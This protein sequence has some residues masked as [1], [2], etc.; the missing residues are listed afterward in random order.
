MAGGN[1]SVTELPK[2]PGFYMNF[3]AAALA[4]ILTG[5]RGVVV[6]PVRSHWGPAKQFIDVVG[7][8]DIIDK[9]TVNETGGA[10]AKT[11]LRLCLLAKPKKIL[12]YRLID[13]SASVASLTLKDSGNANVMTL[14]T[15]YETDRN[16]KVTVQTNPIDA[17]KKDIKLY[18]GTTL[19]RTFT[20]VSGTVQAAVEAVNND[21]GNKWLKA[22]KTDD[23]TGTL[24]NVSNAQFTGGNAGLSE[25]V[26][27]DYTAF[28]TACET[29]KFNIISLDAVTDESIHTSFRAWV[30]RMRSEGKN[31]QGVLGSSTSD[32]TATDAVAKAIARSAGFN[33]EGMINVGTGAV[34]DGVT[35]S[36][37]QIASY[38]AGL[39]AGQNLSESTT[40]APT[41]FDDVTRRWTR[42]E[43]E[44]AVTNGVYLLIHDGRI[45]KPLQGIN[46]LITLR[47]GQNHQFKK[48]RAIRVMDAMNDD[49]LQAAEDNYIGKVNNTEEGRLA[50]I[51]AFKQ[52]MLVHVQGGTIEA[53]GWDVYL[54]PDYYGP[55]ATLDPAADEVYVKWEAYVTDVMEKIYGTFVVK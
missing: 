7:E 16:F 6:L 31:I 15:I 34:L 4:S 43:Q 44:L 17:T 51:A 28:M 29:Q 26:A 12:A 9:Y 40:Y 20:F 2:L 45:V 5:A 13:S 47:Q 25:I 30:V 49:M 35:Y 23:G 42:S 53:T 36:S 54:H 50:L 41:P 37:A 32:D 33:H 48:I 39:I 38:V 11:T 10:N 1:W 55:N 52:Y 14:E 27:A 19:L 21:T 24:A 18:E 3:Q 46:S 22:T 8:Q